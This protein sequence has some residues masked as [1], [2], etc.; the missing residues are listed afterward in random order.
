MSSANLKAKAYGEDE[1]KKSLKFHLQILKISSLSHFIL[2]NQKSCERVALLVF[3][4]VRRAKRREQGN[5]LGSR[6][7]AHHTK[8][9]SIILLLHAGFL[10]RVEITVT[11]IIWK[12]WGESRSVSRNGPY[13][14]LKPPHVPADTSAIGWSLHLK[15][16]ALSSTWFSAVF[17]IYL[18]MVI[19]WRLFILSI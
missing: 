19:I 8:R 5:L 11:N 15:P 3:G 2:N 6:L 9:N 1:G 13:Y 10:W 17:I 12:V 4:N 7:L 14:P 16:E 18:L